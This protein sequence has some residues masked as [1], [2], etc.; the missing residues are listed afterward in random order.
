LA[1]YHLY[2]W[3]GSAGTP[4]SLDVGNQT[5]YTLTGLVDGT[6]YSFA[7]TAYTTLGVE[8][9][10][11]QSITVTVASP[12]VAVA[13]TATTPAGTPATI[14][15]LANDTDPNGSPLTITAVTQGASGT[16]TTSGTTVTYTPGAF[17][18]LDSF[19][20]TVTDDL[21]LSATAPVTVTVTAVTLPP[22]A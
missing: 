9:S 8:S 13:D 12:P 20:Y 22:V 10:E 5:T 18:G 6:I 14:A 11:S 1:G 3:Q 17:V 2:Y 15:V 16:V 7:V 4:Q 21:G 19:T